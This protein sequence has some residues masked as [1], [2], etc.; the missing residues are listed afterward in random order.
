[1]PELRGGLGAWG[2]GH[3]FSSV[4][5][6]SYPSLPFQTCFVDCLIEQTHPEIRKRYDQDVSRTWAEL[7]RM[8][9]DASLLPF[10]LP[11]LIISGVY[12]LL[13]C[14]C[15]LLIGV[16]KEFQLSQECGEY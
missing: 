13:L 4:I 7:L 2:K 16:S 1:M 14:D 8:E 3:R 5:G 10:L 9:R 11:A 6:K 12:R 15:T